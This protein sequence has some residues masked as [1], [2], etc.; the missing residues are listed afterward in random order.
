MRKADGFEE[1]TER[2]QIADQPFAL[3][4]LAHIERDVGAER[5]RRYGCGPDPGHEALAQRALQGEAPSELGRNLR[6]TRPSLDTPS[7]EFPHSRDRA[8]AEAR[9]R[10]VSIPAARAAR[11][12][13]RAGCRGYGIRNRSP[14]WTPAP[15]LSRSR[16]MPPG[17]VA[18]GSAWLPATKSREASSSAPELSLQRIVPPRSSAWQPWLSGAAQRNRSLSSSRSG[19]MPPVL[20]GGRAY[21]AAR[22]TWVRSGRK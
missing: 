9:E 20:R 4:L 21:R 15:Q 5:P 2:S 12:S 19:R 16:T 11:R 18:R 1:A 13:L 17:A 7:F 14:V 8:S 10:Q 3:D 22:C 6:A